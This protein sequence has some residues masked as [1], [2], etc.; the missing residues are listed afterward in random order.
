MLAYARQ[1]KFS[2]L[3]FSFYNIPGIFQRHFLSSSASSHLSTWLSKNTRS[4]PGMALN[5]GSEKI[6]CELCLVLFLY[7]MVARS[8]FQADF[9]QLRTSAISCP[10]CS[11]LQ[12]FVEICEPD[13]E[14]RMK[15][16]YQ[17][18][19]NDARSPSFL[20]LAWLSGIV[21]L[22]GFKLSQHLVSMHSTLD[23]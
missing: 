5:S 14:A 18:A 17:G 19:P 7:T 6:W 11:L 10:V 23:P 22:E 20:A 16:F 8:P 4:S 2:S 13:P 3:L 1:M 9:E 21:K 15:G 12:R